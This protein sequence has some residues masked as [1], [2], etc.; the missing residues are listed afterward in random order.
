MSKVQ[1]ITHNGLPSANPPERIP[2]PIEHA[3]R[4]YQAYPKAQYILPADDLERQRLLIQHGDWK[5]LFGNKVLFAPVTLDANDKVLEVATGPGFWI[6]DLAESVGPLVPMVAV[7]IES[8]LFPVCPPKNI[9][10]GIESVTNLPRD[11]T[12]SFSFVHQRLLILALQVHEWPTAVGELYR[13]LRPGGWVQIAET[14]PWVE[15]EN[16]KTPCMEKLTAMY[17]ALL[18]SR[19]L[20]PD[21][22]QDIPAM[23]EAAGFVDIHSESR[24]QLIGKWAGEIGV[25][26]RVNHVG[27]F[28]G[29]KTPV[30][31]A[32]G[33]GIVT[34]EAEYDDLLDGLDREWDEVPG[35]EKEIVIVWAQKP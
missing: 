8:R 4:I 12:N 34:S 9:T 17:C 3:A 26:H 23:L 10:F 2:A 19:N 13:V 31:D 16:P 27:V 24:I 33:F 18:R 22:A 21:C 28:R 29:I 11:W 20:Y 32:G 30:L 25:T 14:A 1:D 35:T 6:M 7:D 5:T 15:A